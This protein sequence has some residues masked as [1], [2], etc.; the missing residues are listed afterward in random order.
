MKPRISVCLTHYNRP[1]KLGATLASLAAQ[2]RVPDEVFLWDDCSP[3]DPTAVAMEWKD[4]FPHFVY[5]RNPRNLNMPGNLNAVVSQATGDFVANLHDADVFA[6]TLLER[7]SAALEA[8]PDAAF[9]FCRDSRWD[10]PRFVRDWTP[11]PASLTPGAEFFKK[12]YLGRIDSIIWGTVMMRRSVYQELLP[13]D[14]QYKNWADVDMWI[15]AC[16]KGAVAFVSEKLIELD[17]SLTEQRQF[18]FLHKAFVVRMIF[19]GINLNVS[20]EDQTR[21]RRSQ[22]RLWRALWLRWMILRLSKADFRIA[23]EGM[24]YINV[25]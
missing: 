8:H 9:V 3:K 22:R 20:K 11:E 4:R 15:R 17:H 25:S 13:F 1:E 12:Y 10:N 2:T 16:A 5:H 6:P 21:A 24:R 19:E 23:A 18:R 14:P 7:W